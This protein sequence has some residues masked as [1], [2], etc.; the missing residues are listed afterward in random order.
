MK[1]SSLYII[2]DEHKHMHYHNLLSTYIHIVFIFCFLLICKHHYI[3]LAESKCVD[4]IY[5]VNY[6]IVL[7]K[8]CFVL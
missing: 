3:W 2:I 1:E 5:F 8:I 7:S 4:I 6:T